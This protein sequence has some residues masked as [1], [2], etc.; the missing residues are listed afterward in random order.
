MRISCRVDGSRSGPDRTLAGSAVADDPGR[1]LVAFLIVLATL[2]IGAAIA[3]A[4]LGRST[5]SLPTTSGSAPFR[6][7]SSSPSAAPTVQVTQAAAIAACRADYATV[8]T[9]ESAYEAIN[10]R[11]AGNVRQLSDLLKD[12]VTNSSFAINI[13]ANHPGQV[14]VATPGHAAASGDSNC[15]FA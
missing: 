11:P 15:A 12:S 10:G 6:P 5:G 2:G 9:T 13:D 4:S 3:V 1:G 7:A 14:D 8:S